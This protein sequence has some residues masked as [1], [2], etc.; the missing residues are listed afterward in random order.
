MVGPKDLRLRNEP[1]CRQTLTF[2]WDTK[3]NCIDCY[4]NG[5]GSQRLLH[6]NTVADAN[7]SPT[8][9]FFGNPVLTGPQAQG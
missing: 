8:F 7:R 1:K 6:M 2:E 4:C 3:S 5:R 9:T